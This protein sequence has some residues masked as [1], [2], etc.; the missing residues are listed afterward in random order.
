MGLR[1]VALPGVLSARDRI[2]R[3]RLFLSKSTSLSSEPSEHE[4]TLTGRGKAMTK[5]DYIE[6]K[7]VRTG[8]RDEEA[9]H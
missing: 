5:Y 9:T 7:S 4:L 2:R 8:L 3:D 6:R 1:P